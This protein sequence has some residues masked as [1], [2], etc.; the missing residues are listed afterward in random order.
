MTRFVLLAFLCLGASVA[1]ADGG[2]LPGGASIEFDKLFIHEDNKPELAEPSSEDVQNAYFNFAHCACSQAQSAT[3]IGGFN[4]HEFAWD[5]VVKNF[6]TAIDRPLEIWTGTTCSDEQLR[7]ENCSKVATT[8]NI[9]VINTNNHQTVSIPIFKLMFPQPMA[10]GCSEIQQSATTWVLADS[11]GDGTLDYSVS[12]GI[13]VDTQAPSLPTN[14]TAIG[15]ESAIDI[16]WT[17]PPDVTDIAYYQAMCAVYAGGAPGKSDRPP[18]R[19]QTGRHLCSIS[20]DPFFTL[21]S[22]ETN[23]DVDA[24]AG[25][26][27]TP[28]GWTEADPMYLCAESGSS[29]AK[30]IR[31]EGLKNGTPY[32]VGVLVMDKAGNVAGTYFTSLLVP[33]PA[34]DF[35]EDLHDRGSGVEGG[36]CLLAQTFGDDNPLTGTLRS[37]RDNTL[38]D[39]FYGRW[40][41]DVYYGTVGRIDLHGSVALRIVAG[42][43]LLPL[44]ALALLWHLLTLPGLVVLGALFVMLR[45]RM[46]QLRHAQL[47]TAATIALVALVPARAHAQSPYWEESGFDRVEGELPPGDPMRVRWHA[48]LRV[49]PY[50]PAIDSQID[51]PVGKFAGPYEQM[52]GGYTILPM[53][54][55]DYIIWRGFGQ[56]GVGASL[57]YMGKKEHAWQFG[58]DPM[59]P[60]RPR[61]PGDWNKFRLFPFSLNAVYRF[62]FLDDEYGIPIIPYVRGGAAY[63]VWWVTAPNG[64]FAKSCKGPNISTM[65]AKTTAAGASIGVVGSIGVA[66]R[67]ERI[68]EGAARSMRES[69]IEH[70]GFYGEY[71]LGKIDGFGSDKKLSVGDATWFAGVDFEF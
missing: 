25:T 60:K 31:I 56:L 11:D 29:T 52:F 66:I 71:S 69:G 19:Y 33:Q 27:E 41:I 45:R 35:W 32:I 38:A 63:Y 21:S 62:T 54:D 42:V 22:I 24:G 12:K 9:T 43:L 47:A 65:C 3:P 20:D 10:S 39:T 46:V 17:P 61:A 57:G 13:T 37:F 5:L 6:T 26:L 2:M 30:G 59:D 49:G 16:A 1:H 50:I 14:F 23:T 55:V 36:F 53:V 68:D 34:T 40:L 51:M 58:S 4:E 8:P 70:A 67:A 64:D 28:P 44:V 15:A 48:G 7:P 18:A